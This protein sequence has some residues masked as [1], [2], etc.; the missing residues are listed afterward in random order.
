MICC[1]NIYSG[2]E[3]IFNEHITKLNGCS[4][5]GIVNNFHAFHNPILRK[6]TCGFAGNN[7]IYSS[8]DLNGCCK[9][10]NWIGAFGSCVCIASLACVSG[11]GNYFTVISNFNSNTAAH[12][13]GYTNNIFLH[14]LHLHRNLDYTAIGKILNHIIFD[15]NIFHFTGCTSGSF[16]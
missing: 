4:C 14:K 15:D 11:Y 9:A 8:V 10:S 3:D 12:R 1:N 6:S 2:S 7:I 5:R 16:T 13:A